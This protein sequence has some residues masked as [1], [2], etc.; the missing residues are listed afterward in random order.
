MELLTI[1]KTKTTEVF[2]T[3]QNKASDLRHGLELWLW[4]HE[5]DIELWTHRAKVLGLRTVKYVTLGLMVAVTLIG[6]AL[7]F[8]YEQAEKSLEA[9]EPLSQEEVEAVTAA[10]NNLPDKDLDA[11]WDDDEDGNGTENMD[12]QGSVYAKPFGVSF[13]DSETLRALRRLDQLISPVNDDLPGIDT[14]SDEIDEYDP[15]MDADLSD[16]A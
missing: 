13:P 10:L 15:E 5:E 7:A 3:V 16:E 6:V 11:Y 9:E 14:E 12:D 2:E 8:V 1:A 4:V